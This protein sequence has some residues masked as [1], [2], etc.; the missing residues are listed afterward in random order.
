MKQEAEI[1][2]DHLQCAR[3]CFKKHVQVLKELGV[4]DSKK[5]TDKKSS[6]L[7]NKLLHFYLTHY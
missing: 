2:L 5:L 7:Q 4:D 3:L 6:N 1:I